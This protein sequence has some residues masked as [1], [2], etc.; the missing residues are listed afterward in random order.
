MQRLQGNDLLPWQGSR[1]RSS[2]ECALACDSYEVCPGRSLADIDSA[3]KRCHVGDGT[4]LKTS[5]AIKE[6][7]DSARGLNSRIR[8][9]IHVVSFY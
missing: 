3:P 4:I 8:V 6:R 1:T 2:Q 7:E 9:R 5:S